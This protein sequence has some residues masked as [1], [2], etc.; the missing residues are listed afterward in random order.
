MRWRVVKV[1]VVKREHPAHSMPERRTII[2]W[3][4][5]TVHGGLRVAWRNCLNCDRHAECAALKLKHTRLGPVYV[6]SDTIV[7]L[8]A[9]LDVTHIIRICSDAQI[10]LLLR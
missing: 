1:S 10:I 5:F 2:S 3:P 7:I 9:I 6:T 4:N 8:N